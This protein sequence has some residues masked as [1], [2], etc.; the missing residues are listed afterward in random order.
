MAQ[1]QI[2][3]SQN[4]N[5]SFT[6]A[7]VGERIAAFLIDLSIISAF[8]IVSYFIFFKFMQMDALQFQMDPWS[9]R[10]LMILITLPAYV[11]TLTT[12]S[13]MEGQTFGKKAM[14]IKVVKIDGYQA[15]F[16]DYLM[17]WVF[18]LVDIWSNSGMVGLLGM[19][20]SKENQ[21]IGDMATGTAVIS[22]KNKVNISHTILEDVDQNYT[23]TYKQVILLNDNDVRIIKDT[24]YKALRTNDQE[25]I[26]R[27]AEKIR[28]TI[29]L[30]KIPENVT[31]R[32]FIKTVLADYSFIT[33][34]SN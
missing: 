25:V 33:G 19:I 3:T 30:D 11:Y 32:N 17:R 29:N 28:V 34:R 12:E 1:I 15:S 7:A 21:R 8:L 26:E 27:L 31:Y 13:L 22:L 4:V 6:L 16:A 20:I 2:N 5:V 10:A 9:F 23:A 18:R 14:K 24:F